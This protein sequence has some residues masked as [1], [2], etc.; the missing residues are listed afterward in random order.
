MCSFTALEESII[1]LLQMK[2][3]VDGMCGVRKFGA[4]STHTTGDDT[5]TGKTSN[6]AEQD[7]MITCVTNMI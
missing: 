1:N 3:A 5:A 4:N 2:E 6:N 7:Y